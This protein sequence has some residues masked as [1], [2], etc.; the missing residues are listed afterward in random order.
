MIVLLLIL[1]LGDALTSASS[2]SSCSATR[3]AASA[4]E[5]LDTYVYYH[6]VAHGDWGYGAAA[7]LFKGVVGLVARPGRQQV[8]ALVR[9]AGGVHRQSHDKLHE[10][11]RG[12]GGE[13]DRGSGGWRQA[14]RAGADRRS[15]SLFPL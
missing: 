2:S 15:R 4:A 11:V 12:L 6:G 10:L 5:V 1:R 7:G 3:S 9:R 13:A 14:V 8:R